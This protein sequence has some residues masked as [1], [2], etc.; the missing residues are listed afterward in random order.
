MSRKNPSAPRK[1]RIAIAGATG[2]VGAALTGLLASD[3]VDI[4]LLTRRPGVTDVPKGAIV[5]A[6]VASLIW[7]RDRRILIPIGVMSVLTLIAM[8]AASS[9]MRR[10][11]G[12]VSSES[13][14]EV[15]ICGIPCRSR[16][17]SPFRILAVDFGVPGLA[18]RDR[19]SCSAEQP[20]SKARQPK[21]SPRQHASVSAS[22]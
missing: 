1:E 6:G 7:L 18:H 10:L 9:Q 16:R 12:F 2:R 3:P 22:L 20:I 17:F 15:S 21:A 19:K 4:T 8:L 5:A 14:G 11:R 13:T